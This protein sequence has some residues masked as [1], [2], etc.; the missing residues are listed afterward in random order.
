MPVASDENPPR[1]DRWPIRG[2]GALGGIL[3]ALTA[4]PFVRPV[5]IEFRDHYFF[6][7]SGLGRRMLYVA[8]EDTNSPA[9]FWSTGWPPEQ[10]IAYAW[11]SGHKLIAVRPFKLLIV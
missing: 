8:A 3:V 7:G 1:R 6:A 5:T 2:L 9:S 11:D 4:V 10:S